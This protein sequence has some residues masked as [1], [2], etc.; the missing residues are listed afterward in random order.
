MKRFIDIRGQDACGRFCWFDTIVSQIET[1]GGNTVWDTFAEFEQDY[2]GDIIERYRG[3]AP[4]WA[5]TGDPN[6]DYWTEE[7][8]A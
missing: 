5:L 8:E 7:T 3:L 2:R 1:H 4:D 6:D